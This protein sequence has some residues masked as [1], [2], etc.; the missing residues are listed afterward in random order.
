MHLAC[1]TGLSF[2]LRFS[3][4]FSMAESTRNSAFSM[5]MPR[6]SRGAFFGARALWEGER[7][8]AR[9]ECKEGWCLCFA[10]CRLDFAVRHSLIHD[11]KKDAER[12][13]TKDQYPPHPAVRRCPGG[14]STP[15][16]VPPRLLPKGVSHPDG[17]ASG[18]AS[19]DAVAE[20]AGVL[21]AAPARLQRCTSR[22]GL[23]AGGLMPEAARERFATPSAGTVLA[24]WPGMP[25]DHLL[26]EGEEADVIETVTYVKG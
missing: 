2:G 10:L 15:V 4:A 26:H 12:R 18:H 7:R 3:P 8:M 19:R 1:C 9:S 5:A 14:G 21:P 25:P 16:G 11:L 24:R 23:S 22:A 17:S 6:H 13:Q 20:R